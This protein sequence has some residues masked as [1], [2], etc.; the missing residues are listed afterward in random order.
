MSVPVLLTIGALGA[1]WVGLSAKRAALPGAGTDGVKADTSELPDAGEPVIESARDALTVAQTGGG[2]GVTI[3]EIPTAGA[4]GQVMTLTNAE[5]GLAVDP[6]ASAG[7]ADGSNA[8]SITVVQSALSPTSNEATP[9]D[10]GMV[11][12]NNDFQMLSSALYGSDQEPSRSQASSLIADYG[13][14][15]GMVW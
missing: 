11:L 4:T 9:A 3:G 7:G 2:A 13:G 12:M 5:V 10:N 8:R 1:A 15:V 14:A 6:L